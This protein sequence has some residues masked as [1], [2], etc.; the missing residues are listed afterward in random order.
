[1]GNFLTGR[2]SISFTR[3][4][5]QGVTTTTTT[6]RIRRTTITRTTTIGNLLPSKDT[7]IFDSGYDNKLYREI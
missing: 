2:D 4:V 6:T 1:V 5:L 3:N 7:T